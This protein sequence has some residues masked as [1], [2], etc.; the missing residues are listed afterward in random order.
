MLDVTFHGDFNI[1]GMNVTAGDGFAE[2][3]DEVPEAN[4]TNR[5]V[6]KDT[7]AECKTPPSYS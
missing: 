6:K 1:P 3:E 4:A 5:Y 7:C 2:E